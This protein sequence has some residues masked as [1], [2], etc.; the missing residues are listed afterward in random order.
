MTTVTS[1]PH[2]VP[3]WLDLATP[4][5]AASQRFYTALFGWDFDR[6]PTDNP[7]GDYIMARRNGHDAAGMMQLSPEMA[8]SGMPPVWSA[9]VTV[10]DLDAAVSKV[11]AAGGA[12]RQPSMDA[13]DAGRFAV[14]ADPAGA[15]ICLWQAKEHLGAGIVNEHGAFSWCELITPDPA[16][17]VPFYE[18]VFG[19]TAE[20]A[21]MPNGDYTLFR[22]EGGNENGIAGAMAPPMEGMPAF[23]AVYFMVDDAAAAVATAKELGAQV[24]MEATPMPGVG[25]L[26]TIVDPQGAVFSLMQPESP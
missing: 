4:D 2:G 20:T 3:S 23:W 18:A 19:W 7:D 25:T 14:I 13:M 11:E 5:P 12:V 8:A 6:Q 24:M 15:V 1:Y 17:V 26:A 21:P 16:A 10:D 22:V 9:Y